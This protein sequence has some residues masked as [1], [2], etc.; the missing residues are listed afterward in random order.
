MDTKQRVK[1]CCIS[2]IA[3]VM[4]KATLCNRVPFFNVFLCRFIL[5]RIGLATRVVNQMTQNGPE[6]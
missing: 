6:K 2:Q 5:Y 3:D 1:K 4:P